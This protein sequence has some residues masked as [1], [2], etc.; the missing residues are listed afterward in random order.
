[1]RNAHNAPQ[2]GFPTRMQH[3]RRR[4]AIAR[5]R[6]AIFRGVIIGATPLLATTALLA[7]TALLG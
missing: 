3:W 2:R 1:M 7:A 6:R 4:R 5:C